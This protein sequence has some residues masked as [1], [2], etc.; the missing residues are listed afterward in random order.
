MAKNIL[1]PERQVFIVQQITTCKETGF[2]FD[3]LKLNFIVKNL[4]STDIC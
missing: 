3:P 4:L 1:N 2:L